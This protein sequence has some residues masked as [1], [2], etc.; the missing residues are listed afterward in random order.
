MSGVIRYV[1]IEETTYDELMATLN[2]ISDRL[3][4]ITTKGITLEKKD[5]ETLLATLDRINN[6]LDKSFEYD[7]SDSENPNGPPVKYL[8]MEYLKKYLKIS[9]DT[10]YRFMKFRNLPTTKIG[11]RRRFIKSEIDAWVLEQKIGK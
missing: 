9:D 5:H 3:E 11:S 10:V 2:K 7:R 6:K 1:T 8:S 4:K